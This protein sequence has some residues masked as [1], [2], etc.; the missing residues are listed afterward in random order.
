MA[1]L[2]LRGLGANHCLCCN[3]L[4]L[5]GDETSGKAYMPAGSGAAAESGVL[6]A[7]R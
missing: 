1:A 5:S 4:H 6:P 7:E 3:Q 2:P